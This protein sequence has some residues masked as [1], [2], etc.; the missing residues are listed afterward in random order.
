MITNVQRE[1]HALRE[2]YA[3][4]QLTHLQLTYLPINLLNGLI[5]MKPFYQHTFSARLVSD[6]CAIGL[7]SILTGGQLRAV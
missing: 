7:D 2:I 5:N 6:L 4:N 3:Y 1:Q